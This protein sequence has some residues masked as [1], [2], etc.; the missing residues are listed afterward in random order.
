MVLTLQPQQQTDRQQS[1]R[2]ASWPPKS[3]VVWQNMI[4]MAAGC[5]WLR[6]LACTCL[7][8]TPEDSFT[9]PALSTAI[10]TPQYSK[11]MCNLNNASIDTTPNQLPPHESDKKN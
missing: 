3:T 6:R 1:Q 2:D 9:T 11:P 5:E 4:S 8:E 10:E 7:K